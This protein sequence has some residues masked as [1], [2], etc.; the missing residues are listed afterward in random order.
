MDCWLQSDGVS[1]YTFFDGVTQGKTNV[2]IKQM[3]GTT[4]IALG[5]CLP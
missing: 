4:D 5:R 2:N 1:V 3:R